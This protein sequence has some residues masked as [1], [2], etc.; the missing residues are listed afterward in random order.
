MASKPDAPG[1]QVTRRQRLPASA[2]RIYRALTDPAALARWFCD[3]AEVDPRPG[4]M[5]VFGGPHAYGGPE[6]ARGRI[7]TIASIPLTTVLPCGIYKACHI[8]R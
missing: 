4:G 2:E 8:S 3:V 5:Y 1:I 6:L 7:M